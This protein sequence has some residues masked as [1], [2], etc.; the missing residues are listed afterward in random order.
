MSG[1]TD[2]DRFRWALDRGLVRRV[3]SGGRRR[4]VVDPVLLD[5]RSTSDQ[6]AKTL[7][8]SDRTIQRKRKERRAMVRELRE[9]KT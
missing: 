6:L 1:V 2:S 4:I 3:Q 8:L 5:S 7:G 9:E